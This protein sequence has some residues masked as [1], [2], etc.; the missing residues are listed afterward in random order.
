M[1]PKVLR[2]MRDT[3]IRRA[4]EDLEYDIDSVTRERDKARSERDDFKEQALDTEREKQDAVDELQKKI[5]ELDADKK[6]LAQRCKRL[7][8]F[9][10]DFKLQ[11]TFSKWSGGKP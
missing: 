10:V 9:I 11:D 1:I 4:V 2:E 3:R 6:E 8:K 5:D 7:E